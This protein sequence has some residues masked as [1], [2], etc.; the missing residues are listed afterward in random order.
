M[1]LITLWKGLSVEI[2]NRNASELGPVEGSSAVVRRGG[3]GAVSPAGER[4][5]GL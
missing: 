1:G 4:R 5:A 2:H 3:W